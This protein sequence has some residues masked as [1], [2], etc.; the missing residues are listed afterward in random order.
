MLY[1]VSR[2]CLARHACTRRARRISSI[3]MCQ[4]PS[5][6]V[7]C[8][9]SGA[10]RPGPR[11]VMRVCS[12]GPRTVGR[13]PLAL[14]NVRR[15][16]APRQAA[17]PTV[18]ASHAS[19]A[20]IPLAVLTDSYKACHPLMYPNASKMVAVRPH[21]WPF[22]AVPRRAHDLPLTRVP[23]RRVPQGLSARQRP[24]R[25]RQAH[26][27]L[28]HSLHRGELPRAALDAGRRGG[29]RAFLQVRCVLRAQRPTPRAPGRS[30]TR[31]AAART[32]RASQSTPFRVSSSRSS[33]PRTTVRF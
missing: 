8:R 27:R 28:W 3:G 22:T 7:A 6:L 14:R 30:L 5:L 17:P 19:F 12:G 13:Q 11:P 20:S 4:S 29:R 18:M 32:T 25:G 24:R 31:L 26:C 16:R 9:L 10:A 33:S 15:L 21:A 1:R 2:R 23:V